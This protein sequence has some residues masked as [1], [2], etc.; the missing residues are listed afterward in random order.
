MTDRKTRATASFETRH[1]A[2]ARREASPP[3][4]EG[5]QKERQGQKQ[6]LCCAEV[7]PHLKGEMWGTRY[8]YPHT[9]AGLELWI[10]GEVEPGSGDDVAAY[11]GAAFGGGAGGAMPPV[12]CGV[13]GAGAEVVD[14]DAFFIEVV[15]VS[16]EPA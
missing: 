5:G 14:A 15:E 11:R 10:E 16:G 13:D 3:L 12:L 1:P 2:R 8:S 9:L 7:I 4:R 6:I